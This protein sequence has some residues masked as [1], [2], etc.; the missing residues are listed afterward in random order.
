MGMERQ[1]GIAQTIPVVNWLVKKEFLGTETTFEIVEVYK[2]NE[3]T[4]L[5]LRC[6]SGRE[7]LARISA[8]MHNE[9]I[10]HFGD[11]FT[12]WE[13]REIT[14]KFSEFKPKKEGTNLSEGVTMSLVWFDD[15]VEIEQ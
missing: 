2:L 10:Q 6:K 5:K 1:T 13:E 12:M 14:I 15:D 4:V 7:L 9:L 3:D 11:N 8:N